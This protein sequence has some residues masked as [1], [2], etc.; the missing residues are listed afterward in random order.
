MKNLKDRDLGFDGT[1]NSVAQLDPDKRVNAVPRQW[2]LGIDV[3][4]RDVE[5]VRQL[6]AKGVHE[7]I[8]G[9]IDA[10]RRRESL[11]K[12]GRGELA[13][14]RCS[15]VEADLARNSQ[16]AKATVVPHGG[17]G[18]EGVEVRP[19][20]DLAV[21]EGTSQRVSD[22]AFDDSEHG[23]DVDGAEADVFDTRTEAFVA[24]CFSFCHVADGAYSAQVDSD[25]WLAIC[26]AVASESV[27]EGITCSIVGLRHVACYTGDR[28]QHDEEGQVGKVFV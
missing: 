21:R 1:A 25:G 10:S 24:A 23:F 28:G 2:Q 15:S 26:R 17:L 8:R 19:D 18:G 7:Q 13:I 16:R 6:S 14:G 27:L 11:D 5:D 9:R 4:Q 22:A 12:C 3:R 20:D